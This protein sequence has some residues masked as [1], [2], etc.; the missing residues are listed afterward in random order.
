MICALV[1]LSLLVI[2]R[3]WNVLIAE[4]LSLNSFMHDDKGT[5]LQDCNQW[6]RTLKI[7]II[8]PR[9]V[10]WELGHDWCIWKEIVIVCS[11]WFFWHPPGTLYWYLLSTG[12]SIVFTGV[13]Q[14]S[15]YN[16]FCTMVSD[17]WD[18][19]WP[20]HILRFFINCLNGNRRFVK[21]QSALNFYLKFLELQLGSS[22]EEA[23]IGDSILYL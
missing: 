7:K 9:F 6:Y 22:N 2:T 12:G 17:W 11:M 3:Y 8:S 4:C 16:S 1:T 20:W 19:E 5:S 23:P 14:S 15:L 13:A 10:R 18:Q 21:S